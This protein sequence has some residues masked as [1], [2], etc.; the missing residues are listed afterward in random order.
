M[1]YRE[2]PKVSIDIPLGGGTLKSM[3]TLTLKIPRLHTKHTLNHQGFTIVELLI[4]IVIIGI[5]AAISIVAYTNVQNQANDTAVSSD[6]S[7]FQKKVMLF[8]VGEGRYPQSN[9]ELERLELKFTEHSITLT[10]VNIT[11]CTTAARIEYALLIL[12]KSGKR[13]YISSQG[14]VS[15]FTGENGWTGSNHSLKCEQVLPGSSY[16]SG[17]YVRADTP[18]PWKAW[19]GVENN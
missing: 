19:T 10:A 15:E 4:V 18:N 2:M 12:S 14:G 13:L 7:N 17:G 8:Q 9:T 16:T 1:N 3:K 5:L 6:L 11:Y